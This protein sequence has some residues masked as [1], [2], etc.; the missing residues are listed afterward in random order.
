MSTTYFD[1]MGKNIPNKG[2]D[3]DRGHLMDTPGSAHD[4]ITSFFFILSKSVLQRDTAALI[5]KYVLYTGSP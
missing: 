4:F 1:L 5:P 2:G 3:Y